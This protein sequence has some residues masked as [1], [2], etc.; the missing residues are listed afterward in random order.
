MQP[1]FH[2][3]ILLKECLEERWAGWF[4]GFDLAVAADGS[5]RLAGDVLDRAALHGVLERIRDLNLSLVS[6]QVTELA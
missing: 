2:V 5:T 1:K 4:D 6:L 3:E